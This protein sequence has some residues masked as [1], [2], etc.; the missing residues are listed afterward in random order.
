LIFISP[1][2]GEPSDEVRLRGDPKLVN[3]IKAE[4]ENIVSALRD[5]V[6]IAVEIPQVQHRA[7][8]GRGGQHLNDLQNKYNVQV[9][10]PGSRSYNQVGEPENKE[11]FDAVDSVNIVKVTGSRKACEDTIEELKGKIKPA[12]P[13]GVSG[14]VTVPFKYHHAVTQQGAL[15][16]ALRS[17]GV[18]VDLPQQPPKLELPSRPAPTGAA[19]ARIDEPDAAEES[20]EVTWEVVANYEGAQEGESTWT[21]NARD[22]A[23]L[24]KATEHVQD[25]IEHAQKMS[26][27]GFLTLPDRSIFPRIIGAKG[28]N[29]ARLRAETG[30]DI[31]VSR[32]TN[33]VV[34]I[35]TYFAFARA[36]RRGC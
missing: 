30:A 33:T 24:E 6:V 25:A 19:T 5:R 21:L 12:A 3:K 11:E 32:D 35:G 9:Q 1:R 4:L 20:S 13:E 18:N 28:A 16:R 15:F 10:F 29:V 34:I 36:P 31:Q 27:V 23:G 14:T 17:F 22:A 7:L 26:K 2:Q 8:I